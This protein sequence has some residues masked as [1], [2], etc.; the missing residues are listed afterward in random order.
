MLLQYNAGKVELKGYIYQQGHHM[1]EA[2]AV[3]CIEQ[4]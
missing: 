2:A 1:E 4:E 3:R